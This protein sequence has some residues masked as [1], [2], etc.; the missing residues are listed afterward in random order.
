MHYTAS[1]D[2]RVELCR[3]KKRNKPWAFRK[4]S[5]DALCVAA[6]GIGADAHPRA[7]TSFKEHRLIT[8]APV[9]QVGVSRAFQYTRLRMQIR[10]NEPLSRIV[11]APTSN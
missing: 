10:N 3:K 2:L 6:A 11:T 7:S 4:T 1:L 8:C 9:H 5:R